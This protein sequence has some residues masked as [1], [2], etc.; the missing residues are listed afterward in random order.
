MTSS[1]LPGKPQ[2]IGHNIAGKQ[3]LL[4]TKAEGKIFHVKVAESMVLVQEIPN[5]ADKG[6]KQSNNHQTGKR[7]EWTRNHNQDW[8]NNN[9]AS[10]SEK[11]YK[12]KIWRLW[13]KH[14]QT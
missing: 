8:I 3:C 14:K 6:E 2:Y 9:S 13:N 5:N 10:F 7:P 11:L 12:K 4:D 1:S